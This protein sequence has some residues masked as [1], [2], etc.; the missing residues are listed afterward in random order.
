[1]GAGLLGEPG[2]WEGAESLTLV[3]SECFPVYDVPTTTT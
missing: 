1:M 2:L 3:C